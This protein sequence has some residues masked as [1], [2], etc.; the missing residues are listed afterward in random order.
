MSTKTQ[1]RKDTF[2]FYYTDEGDDVKLRRTLA[3]VMQYASTLR[4][5]IIVYYDD[6]DKPLSVIPISRSYV[7]K[8]LVHK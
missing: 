3:D 1:E 4:D 7:E 2:N 6:A 8:Y 5:N